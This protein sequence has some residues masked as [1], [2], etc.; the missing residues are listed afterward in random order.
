MDSITVSDMTFNYAFA[1][2]YTFYIR[3]ANP[4]Y[5]Q[6]S[7]I[8]LDKTVLYNNY[9]S[10]SP[11]NGYTNIKIEDPRHLYNENGI[12]PFAPEFIHM[13]FRGLTSE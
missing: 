9:I 3:Y 8:A 1:L 13:L 2:E 11:K 5:L 6:V 12:F 10:F 4:P 7:I